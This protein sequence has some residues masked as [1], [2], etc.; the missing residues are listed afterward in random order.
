[1][2]RTQTF[3]TGVFSIFCNSWTHQGE[4]VAALLAPEARGEVDAVEEFGSMSSGTDL[5]ESLSSTKFFTGELFAALVPP[6]ASEA[7][8]EFDAVEVFWSMALGTW[9]PAEV[10]V[11][12]VEVFGWVTLGTLPPPVVPP[13]VDAIEPVVDNACLCT[14]STMRRAVEQWETFI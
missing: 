11:D 14:E 3:G 8:S 6:E 10:E 12:A 2:Y 1:M 5:K 9:V 13:E 4:V 7:P